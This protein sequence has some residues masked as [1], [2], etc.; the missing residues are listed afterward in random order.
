MLT[1]KLSYSQLLLLITI[2]YLNVESVATLDGLPHSVMSGQRCRQMQPH[3]TCTTRRPP[4]SQIDQR[5]TFELFLLVFKSLNNLAPQ[6]LRQHIKLLS[7][8]PGR[9]RLRSSETFQLSVPHTRTSAR[10]HAFRV[11]AW[12]VSLE[13]SSTFSPRREYCRNF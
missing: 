11:S 4:H 1:S 9:Q 8:E 6:Y 2:T 5:I 7:D 12:I 10:K 3:R 13:F